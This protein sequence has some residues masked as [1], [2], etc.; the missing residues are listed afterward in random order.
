MYQ[1]VLRRPVIEQLV[2]KRSTST[3]TGLPQGERLL[4]AG[5]PRVRVRPQGPGPVSGVTTRPD[6]PDYNW[7]MSMPRP[8]FEVP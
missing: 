8:S 2:Q 7:Q 4:H 6:R 3:T 5:R 1:S